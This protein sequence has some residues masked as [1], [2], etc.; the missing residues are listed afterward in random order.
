MKKLITL[1]MCML[2]V[3]SMTACSKS[4]G[5]TKDSQNQKIGVFMPAKHLQRWNQDGQNLKSVLEEKGYKVDLQYA[6]N[7]SS[8]QKSQIKKAIENDYNALIISAVDSK[9]LSDTL[10]EAKEK[11]IKVVAY[12]RL[13]M[14]TD[15][16]SCYATFDNY[17]VGQIQGQY[18]IDSLG[19][20]KGKGPYNLEIFAGPIDDNNSYYLMAGA[21]DKLQMYIDSGKLVIQ[22]GKSNIK[23]AETKEWSTE[24]AQ[25]RMSELLS[26][27]YSDKKIDAVLCANDSIALGVVN[28][29]KDANYKTK[30]FPV[31]TGEDCDIE[32]V[33]DIIDG[34]Q[35]MSVFKDTRIL[36]DK[37]AVMLQQLFDG[38]KVD[39]NDDKS[40]DNGKGV[41]PTYLCTPGFVDKDN[42]KEVILDTNYYTEDQLK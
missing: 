13:I 2:V 40:Y 34:T 14:D 41:V 1:I 38:E 33:K 26:S 4:E 7:D 3:L 31:I 37:V 9:S 15:A 32:S 17:K 29:F 23:D 6:E 42:Y 16:V 21:M 19:L 39:S 36:A 5:V 27:T 30:D 35:S 25:K 10:A 22:S 24:N 28:A 12:D 18:I 20:D 8:I 11:D